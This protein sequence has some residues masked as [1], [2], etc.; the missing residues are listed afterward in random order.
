MLSKEL[1]D[2]LVSVELDASCSALLSF[3]AI[4]C[5]VSA[6]FISLGASMISFAS[7]IGL[8]FCFSET[9]EF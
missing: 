2:V 6:F 5:C 1:R 9:D 8:D 3:G 7:A 4:G